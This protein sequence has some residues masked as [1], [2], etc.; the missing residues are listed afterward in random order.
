MTLTDPSKLFVSEESQEK[1]LFSASGE[2]GLL[3]LL[4]SETSK[5]PVNTTDLKNSESIALPG[6]PPLFGGGEVL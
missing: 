4:G 3:L 2:G 5:A 6:T 1:T